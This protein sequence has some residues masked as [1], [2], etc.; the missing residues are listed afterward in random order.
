MRVIDLEAHFYTQDYVNYLRKRSGYP[1]EELLSDGRVKLHMGPGL[2]APRSVKLEQALCELGQPRLD[3]MD[4]AGVSMQVLSLAVPGCEQFEPEEGTQVA[5]DANDELADWLKRYP[6]RYLGLAALAPQN[7]EAAADELERCVTKLGMKG[8]KLNSHCRGEYLD[9]PKFWP[10]F[11]RAEVLGAPIY[12]HPTVPSTK[13]AEGFQGYGFP[14]AGPPFG[15]QADCSLHSMRLIYS[16]LFDRFPKLK[17]V[18]GHLG[19]GLP[20]WFY[21]IDFYWLKPWVAPELKPK[22]Q[23]KPSEYLLDNFLFTSSGMHYLPAVMCAYMAVGAEGI[24]FGA[25]PPFEKSKEALEHL[26]NLPMSRPDLEKF[27]HGNAERL[28]QLT[29]QP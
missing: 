16:G 11:E 1:R 12:L 15:F 22:A 24:A 23:R 29:P 14:L 2:W 13:I 19:E 27:Y 8:A 20:F 9:D 28:L 3:D 4:E 25:D 18:L 6:D 17:M 5:R 7:P 21:R 10:V 26:S